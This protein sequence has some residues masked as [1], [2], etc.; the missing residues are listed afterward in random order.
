MENVC[1][2]ILISNIMYKLSK[3][4]DP[5]YEVPELTCRAVFNYL[6][7]IWSART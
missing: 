4:R 5:E 6:T 1:P 7:E 3:V 2:Q